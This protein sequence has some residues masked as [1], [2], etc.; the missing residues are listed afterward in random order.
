[1][2]NT[3]LYRDELEQEH[4]PNTKKVNFTIDLKRE[5]QNVAIWDI[6]IPS[7]ARSAEHHGH[8]RPEVPQL[9]SRYRELV[10]ADWL[11]AAFGNARHASS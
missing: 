5:D 9:R 3:S 2:T 10:N 6:E 4:L 8:M 1:M 11:A 7:S